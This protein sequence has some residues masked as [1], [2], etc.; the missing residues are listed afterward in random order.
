VIVVETSAMVAIYRREPDNASYL[1]AIARAE[2]VSFPASCFVESIMALSPF[3]SAK[4]DIER[5]LVK[6]EIGLAPIHEQVAKLAADAFLRFGKGRGHPARL[7]FGDCL[8]YV[9]AK[10][11]DAPLLYKSDDFSRT[12]IESALVA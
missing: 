2:A 5:F 3:P 11:L 4:S 9:V 1:E 8:S 10:H 6:H 12:D 7:N